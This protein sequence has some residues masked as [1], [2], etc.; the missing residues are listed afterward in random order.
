MS[1]EASTTT[2]ANTQRYEAI[3]PSNVAR[4][5][6]WL[7][8][9]PDA[10]RA[11]EVVSEVLPFK[12]NN[13]VVEEL[14]DWSRV[15]DDPIF[16]LTFPQHGMLEPE[17]FA[18]VERARREG[19][20]GRLQAIV[21]AIR[22]SL[23]PHP[24]GQSTLNVPFVDGMPFRGA[25][26]KYSETLLFFPAAG[27]TCHAYC[28][29]CFRWPQFVGQEAMR[30]L[31][32]DHEMLVSY[33]AQHPEITD[34]LITGGDPMVMRTSVLARYIDPILSN[35]ELAHVQTI[36]IGTKSLAYWPQRFV[37]DSDAD[38]LLRL[39]ER[40]IESG[41]TLAIQAH[42][43]HPVEFQPQVAREAIRRVR[44]TGAVIRLQSPCI[45]HVNDDAS[46]WRELWTTGVRLGCIPYY[47]FVERDTGAKRYFELPLARCHEIFREAY[48]TVSGLARTVRGPS[49][50]ATPGKVHVLGQNSVDGQEVF[51]LQ[52]LQCR[53][54]EL[55]RRPFFAKFDR[56]ATWFD[57][58]EPA[59]EEDR[60]F[61]PSSWPSP[62]ASAGSAPESVMDGGVRVPLRISID[63]D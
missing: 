11:I 10:R 38:E 60:P 44:G 9:P 7:R 20:R 24:A 23:N 58:L 27:Q 45:R 28:T 34:L 39:F 15:P 61:F 40:I 17:A 54:P 25:Q 1:T 30:F 33:L 8:L 63:E 18:A 31:A 41:R 51:M 16:Q 26:H 13:H 43:S 59:R 56:S 53:R 47:F 4:H 46:V 42:A 6:L 52:Y 55:V 57:Q 37:T 2:M 36:R 5:P 12:T 32:R 48:S 62:L 19:D 35:P 14:I 49:M 50:S 22:E 21:G 29:F 3:L